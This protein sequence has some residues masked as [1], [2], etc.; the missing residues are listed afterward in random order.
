MYELLVVGAGPHALSVIC[1]LLEE[2]RPCVP[3][4]SADDMPQRYGVWAMLLPPAR[5]LRSQTLL[6]NS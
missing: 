2:V 6:Y 1:R 3:S 4:A 5:Q